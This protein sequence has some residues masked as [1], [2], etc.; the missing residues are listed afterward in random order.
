ML[1]HEVDFILLHSVISTAS[2]TVLLNL[3]KKHGGIVY[4]L[5]KKYFEVILL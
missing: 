4:M 5:I 3:T 2:I 1:V